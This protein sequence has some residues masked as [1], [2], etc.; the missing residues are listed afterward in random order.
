MTADRDRGRREARLGRV[1]RP[2][3][4][5]SGDDAIVEVPQLLLTVEQASSALNISR[6]RIFELLRD[7]S[8]VGVKLGRV[9]RIR[10]TDLQAF[11]SSL[12]AHVAAEPSGGR[13]K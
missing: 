4:T 8:L 1:R 10:S 3:S 5:R 2:P 12:A 6:T 13:P 9:T 7:G 11:V